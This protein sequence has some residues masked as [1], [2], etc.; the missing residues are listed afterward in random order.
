MVLD[1]LK[2]YMKCHKLKY[3]HIIFRLKNITEVNICTINYIIK[4]MTRTIF[5]IN[6]LSFI[7]LFIFF[8]IYKG[9]CIRK[10]VDNNSYFQ[11]K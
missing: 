10:F 7:L 2:F 8:I 11:E 5:N 6:F 4:I 1:P 3:F 9:I